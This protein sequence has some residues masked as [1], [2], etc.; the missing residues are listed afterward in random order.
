MIHFATRPAGK[1]SL[2]RGAK[3]AHINFKYINPL[4]NSPPGS[5]DT[6]N[7]G[8]GD[9]LKMPHVQYIRPILKNW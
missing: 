6:A 4:K 7:T 1:P 8:Q 3:N 9:D 5:K 2:E